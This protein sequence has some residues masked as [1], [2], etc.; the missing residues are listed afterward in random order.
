M[1]DAKATLPVNL[2]NPFVQLLWHT[3]HIWP[4]LTEEDVFLAAFIL[5]L[6]LLD[7]TLFKELG[8]LALVHAGAI[9]ARIMDCLETWM[10]P[11]IYK[12]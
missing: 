10:D 6:V 2:S 11:R 8:Q 1:P 7:F 12:C 9:S 3:T 4:L 5:A